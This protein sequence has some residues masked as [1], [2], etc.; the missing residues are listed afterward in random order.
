MAERKTCAF[1]PEISKSLFDDGWSG[2]VK[3]EERNF[4]GKNIGLSLEV[5]V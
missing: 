4:L 1:D 3:L 2:G 5:Y